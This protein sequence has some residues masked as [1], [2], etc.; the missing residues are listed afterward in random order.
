MKT[1]FLLICEKVLDRIGSLVPYKDKKILSIYFGVPGS[2][3]STFAAALARK[4]F[5]HNIPVFS[6]FPI[7]GSI[8]YGAADL[9]KYQISN[10]KVIIDEA[11][12]EF[13]N[14]DFKSFTKENLMFFKLH[15]HYRCSVDVF[16]QTYNDMDKKIR[17]LAQQLFIVRR[18]HIPFFVTVIRIRKKIAVDEYT[19]DIV[20]GYFI[21]PFWL[22]IITA[23]RVFMPIY[24]KYFDSYAA[25]KLP[26]R[27]FYKYTKR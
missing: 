23:K 14:R 12:I 19:H 5:L 20:D 6:N 24:W 27:P 25:P 1:S 21:D 11:G 22:Q 15:R 16:S 4:C 2:G 17:S 3:K 26:E 7:V 10:C 8:K 13:N 9:G 18:S